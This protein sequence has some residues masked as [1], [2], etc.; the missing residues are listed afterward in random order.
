MSA[1][2]L[3]SGAEAV[4][5]KGGTSR[6]SLGTTKVIGG[7]EAYILSA[8]GTGG[9]PLSTVGCYSTTQQQAPKRS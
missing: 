8:R 3:P 4:L 1:V 9:S 6:S 5:G 2:T 7:K